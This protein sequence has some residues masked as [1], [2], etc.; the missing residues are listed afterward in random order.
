MKLWDVATG[1]FLKEI[2]RGASFYT[3]AFFADSKRALSVGSKHETGF[4]KIW[5]IPSGKNLRTF[6]LRTKGFTNV[7]SADISRDGSLVLAAYEDPGGNKKIKVWNI[8]TARELREIATS[9]GHEAAFSPDNKFIACAYG[10]DIEVWDF[11]SGAKILSFSWYTDGNREFVSNIAFSHDGRSILASGNHSIGIWDAKTGKLQKKFE[12]HTSSIRSMLQ[13]PDG[14]HIVTGSW[15][16]T[17]RVWDIASGKEVAKFALFKDGE[18][19]SITPEGYYNSSERGDSHLNVRIG[20]DVFSME[21]YRESFYRPDLVKLALAGGSLKDMKNL[22]HV[23]KPPEIFFVNPPATVKSDEIEIKFRLADQGGG[24]GDVKLMLNGSA[25][26]LDKS[27]GIEVTAKKGKGKGKVKSKIT[28]TAPGRVRSYRLKL[29]SGLNIIEATAF[30]KDNSMQGNPVLHKVQADFR[31]VSKPSLHALIVGINIFE[32][33]KLKLKYAAADAELF[34]QTLNKIAAPLYK[35]VQIKKLTKKNDTT[36]DAILRALTGY[37]KLNPEDVFVLY[38]ASHGTVDEGEYFLLTSNVG[39]LRTERL[40]REALPQSNLKES[41]AN[42]PS[43]K[44]LIIVDTCN[45]GAFG[46]SLQAALATRGMSEDTAIKVLSRATGST[47]LSA[48]TSVQEA[49]EGYKGHGLFTLVLSEGLKGKADKGKT[50][51]VKTSDLADFVD[52]EVPEIAER[53]FKRKQ[54]P[55]INISGQSFPIGRSG[56]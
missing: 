5:E 29:V 25:V 8:N 53:V 10:G 31:M 24:I 32:N 14:N 39:S 22:A 6:Q 13:T 2:D 12:G 45:A 52:T 4:I 55:S 7:N 17:M 15:D 37:Q 26:L 34:A 54:Y 44:K 11:Q 48:S 47:I 51:Y 41:I 27:R 33:P 9:N 21:N 19:I 40:R 20:M 50:G 18:W 16:R 1:K 42:V 23:A 36:K 49:F 28:A 56:F 35:T 3:T 46:D 30:N 38:V 43:T